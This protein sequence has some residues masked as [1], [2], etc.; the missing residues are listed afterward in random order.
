MRV[1]NWSRFQH[2]KDRKP[3]WIKLYRDLLDDLDW[4]R[5]DAEAAKALVM[6]WLIASEGDGELPD[7]DTLAFRLRTT[8]SRLETIVSKLDHWLEHVASTPLAEAEHLASLEKDKEKEKEAQKHGASAP[9]PAWVDSKAWNDWEAYRKETRHPLTPTSRKK[10]L[11]L[12]ARH[13]AR[14]REIIDK[15]IS[16]GW[17]GLFEPKDAPKQS[18]D[19]MG[20]R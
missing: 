17:R 11:E 2:Y 4:H 8:K 15:S 6:M 12:L 10:C 19:H 13:P 7:M 1:K 3:E 16:S 18:R 14:Q 20:A 5:L 9:L